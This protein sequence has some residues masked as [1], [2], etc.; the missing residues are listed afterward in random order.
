MSGIIFGPAV[1][2]VSHWFKRR[3]GLALGIIAVGS[4]LGGSLFPIAFE[5]LIPKV[6][7]VSC[8]TPG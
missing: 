8:C 4:S 7:Y 2:I 1:S 5:Q 3:R 6:G